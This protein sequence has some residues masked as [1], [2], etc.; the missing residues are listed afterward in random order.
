MPL[1]ANAITHL[2]FAVKN[3]CLSCLCVTAKND[4]LR[5]C[6]GEVERKARLAVASTE[7]FHLHV[8]SVTVKGD[9]SM[10]LCEE[11]ALVV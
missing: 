8:S 2:V 10:M 1:D 9:A 5:K 7:R 11:R 4:E 3:H 6:L